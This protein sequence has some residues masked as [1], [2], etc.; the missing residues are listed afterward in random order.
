MFRINSQ[1]FENLQDCASFPH[2]AHCA[3]GTRTR[4]L[5][6]RNDR[7]I[8]GGLDGVHS[9]DTHGVRLCVGVQ[10]GART[11]SFR[12]GLRCDEIGVMH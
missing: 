9:T 4:D 10:D 6:Q 11:R 8:E 2:G 1:G 7:C 12:T 3:V 5:D